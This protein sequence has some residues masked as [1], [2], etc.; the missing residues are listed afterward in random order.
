MSDIRDA[1]LV[2]V[3]MAVAFV[4]CGGLPKKAEAVS[5]PDLKCEPVSMGDEAAQRC[6]NAEVI[7]YT[8]KDSLS[9]VRKTP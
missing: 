1:L 6:E 3:L 4:A 7:C 5:R 2:P 8:Y 9:C